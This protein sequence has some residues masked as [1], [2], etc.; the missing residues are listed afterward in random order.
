MKGDY[1]QDVWPPTNSTKTNNGRGPSDFELPCKYVISRHKLGDGSY[2]GVFECKHKYS[3]MRLAAKMYEKRLV[4]GMESILQNEFLVL[5]KVSMNHDNILTLVDNFE[6]KDEL[7]LVTEIAYGGDLFD[8]VIECEKLDEN[9][10]REVIGSLVSAVAYLHAN[11]IIHKDIKAENVLFKSKSNQNMKVLL[12]DFGLAKIVDP[13][14]KLQSFC[15]TLSYMA[16][17]MLDR[18]GHDFASDMWSLGVLVYF[19]LCGYMPFDCET[20]DET[21]NAIQTADYTYDPPEY[22]QHVSFE[23]KD[24]ID[25]CFDLDPTTR[26][27]A[28]DA[29]NHSFVSSFQRTSHSDKELQDLRASVRQ[30]RLPG[31]DF[32]RNPI[33]SNTSPAVSTSLSSVPS[34]LSLGHSSQTTLPVDSK[35]DGACCNAPETVSKFSTPLTSVNISRVQSTNNLQDLGNLA[36]GN[37]IFYV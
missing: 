25:K 29:M 16:P 9:Q 34:N 13:N 18:A 23:A 31:Q 8:R 1:D 21:K 22:W 20:D 33:S 11:N 6:T 24:F 12:A 14:E 32:L 37:C 19:V 17:E 26:I 3:G 36:G 30:L 35:L 5:K 10:A 27:T 7:Y 2:S 28:L 4:Y 15:G